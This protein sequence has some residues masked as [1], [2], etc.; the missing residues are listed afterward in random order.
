MAKLTK[1]QY[2]D[3]SKKGWGTRKANEAAKD[4][5]TNVNQTTT[6]SQKWNWLPWLIAGLL[7]VSLL[8]VLNPLGLTVSTKAPAATTEATE[9]PAAVAPAKAT[10][11]PAEPVATEAPAEPVVTE[12]P[13]AAAI[14]DVSC[15]ISA[16]TDG[17][18]TWN[19]VGQNLGNRLATTNG[20]ILY[21]HT[22]PYD[23]T[24][25]LPTVEQTWVSF[26][27]VGCEGTFPVVFAGGFKTTNVSYNDGVVLYL[28]NL[29]EFSMRNGELVIHTSFSGM[30]TDVSDRIPNQIINGNLDFPNQK[31]AFKQITAE[32]LGYI[33]KELQNQAEIV[34]IR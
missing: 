27:I 30:H 28:G 26:K 19:S 18:K 16:S 4:N 22:A 5:R 25:E 23:K 34:T 1:K 2:S 9:A 21:G 10:D 33:P 13:A 15:E 17:G 32:F 14:P 7:A 31:L 12:A 3:N 6:S 11:A 29:K 8:I 24:N 20:I